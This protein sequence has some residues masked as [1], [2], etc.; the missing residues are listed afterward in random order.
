MR[1]T[2]AEAN[3][4][5]L[6]AYA[7]MLA[8]PA[9]YTGTCLDCNDTKDHVGD[10]PLWRDPDPTL[11]P[12]AYCAPCIHVRMDVLRAFLKMDVAR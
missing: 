3:R 1:I 7:E 2:V 8:R 5:R 12:D 9:D 6:L 10:V 4:L 11:A